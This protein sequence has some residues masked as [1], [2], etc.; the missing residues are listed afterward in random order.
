VV[1]CLVGE[2]VGELVGFSLGKARP[3]LRNENGG[4]QGIEWHASW[5]S[6]TTRSAHSA[7][8]HLAMFTGLSSNGAP[9]GRFQS[10]NINSI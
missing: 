1:D 2:P 8:A 6:V 5:E 10:S 9:Q 7:P 3:A 4:S